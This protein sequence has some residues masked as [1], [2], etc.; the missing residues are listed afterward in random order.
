MLTANF[1]AASAFPPYSGRFRG[2]ICHDNKMSTPGRIDFLLAK[3]SLYFYNFFA[4]KEI[5]GH[6]D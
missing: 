5:G 2:V 4:C 6:K 3:M 1:E